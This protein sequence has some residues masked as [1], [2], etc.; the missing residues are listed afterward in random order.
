MKNGTH[1]KEQ[2]KITHNVL[3]DMLVDQKNNKIDNTT[4]QLDGSKIA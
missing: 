4:H 2:N 1:Y 3:W